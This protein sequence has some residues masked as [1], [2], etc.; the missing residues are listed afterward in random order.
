MRTARHR[1]G[2]AD[3]TTACR[4]RL[5]A[6]APLPLSAAPD[7]QRSASYNLLRYRLH[8]VHDEKLQTPGDRAVLCAEDRVCNILKLD[9][10]KK[11]FDGSGQMG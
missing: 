8:F 1:P 7:A 6:S 3:L 2:R 5:T 4:R 11:A 10:P 9:V